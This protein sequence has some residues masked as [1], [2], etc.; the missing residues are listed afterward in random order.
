[1][2][3]WLLIIILLWATLLT[4][5]LIY[6]KLNQTVSEK[7]SMP[8]PRIEYDGPIVDQMSSRESLR[9]FIS[10]FLA[11]INDGALDDAL[12][13]I[14]P[15]YLLSELQNRL[16]KSE[17]NMY[18]IVQLFE[19]GEM[20]RFSLSLPNQINYEMSCKFQIYLSTGQS[21][22]YEVII[23]ELTDNHI[24]HRTWFIKDIKEINE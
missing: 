8:V 14:E 9:E 5:I 7:E 17:K 19:K 4:G 13:L 11:C 15:N 16:G 12:S 18:Q 10:H 3:K 6:S 2:K 1:M 20:N 23:V 21:I 24:K 22:S